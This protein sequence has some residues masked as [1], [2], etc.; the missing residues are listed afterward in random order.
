MAN[1]L[2]S[3]VWK[4]ARAHL[5]DAGDAKYHDQVLLPYTQ[6]AVLELED[7]LEEN[8]AETLGEQSATLAVP[9]NTKEIKYTGTTPTLPSDLIEPRLVFEKA[10]GAADSTYIEVS[11]TRVLP[12]RDQSGILGEYTWEEQSLKFVGALVARDIRVL[13]VKGF[14]VL[15]DPADGGQEVPYNNALAYLSFK[16]SALAA[17]LIAQN[18]DRAMVLHQSAEIALART[19]NIRARAQQ[20]GPVRHRKWTRPGRRRMG[21]SIYRTR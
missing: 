19:L 18:H 12:I 17:E 10:T 16:T 4:Q 9:L 6:D 5:N 14:P 1:P 15:T 21:R 8:G 11:Y 3:Q 20:K 13:Y 2:L 7:A